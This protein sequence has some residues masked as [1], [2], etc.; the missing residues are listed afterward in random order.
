VLP[1]ALLLALSAIDAE[2][3]DGFLDALAHHAESTDLK[4]RC[5]GVDPGPRV[6]SEIAPDVLGD[7]LR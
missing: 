3:R 5:G 7:A 4:L 6:G 1:I 2:R